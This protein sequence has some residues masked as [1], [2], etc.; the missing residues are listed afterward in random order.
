MRH[1]SFNMPIDVHHDYITVA[2]ARGV[3]LSA[4]LNW[5][6]VE[7]RPNLLIRHAQHMAA[8][9]RAGAVGLPHGESASSASQEALTIARQLMSQLQEMAAM[10]A[11]GTHGEQR[12]QAG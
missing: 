7:F 4:V 1:V 2:Q 3:D 9:L 8:M 10:L 5:A 11:G 6:L 12:Q